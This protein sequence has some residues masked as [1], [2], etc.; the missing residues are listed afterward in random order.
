MYRTQ[1]RTYGSES[2]VN[3]SDDDPSLH[4]R[5][6]VGCDVV[7]CWL[8]LITEIDDIST[9]NSLNEKSG[10]RADHAASIKSYST[11]I[12]YRSVNIFYSVDYVQV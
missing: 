12:A 10:S 6:H 7:L 3:S 5:C 2:V 4:K 9:T 1:S 8:P 11:R